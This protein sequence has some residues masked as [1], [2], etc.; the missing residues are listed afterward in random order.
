MVAHA[1]M[2]IN[3]F[4]YLSWKTSR[5]AR[6]ERAFSIVV[7]FAAVPSQSTTLNFLFWSCMGHVTW[8]DIL[9]SV[10][11]LHKALMDISF[12]HNWNAFCT[13]DNFDETRSNIQMML[14]LQAFYYQF[15][16]SVVPVQSSH[17]WLWKGKFPEKWTSVS[18]RKAIQRIDLKT[19]SSGLTKFW[20]LLN[21]RTEIFSQRVFQC[22]HLILFSQIESRL[23]VLTSEI[24]RAMTCWLDYAN[25]LLSDST[26][27]S[28]FSLGDFTLLQYGDKLSATLTAKN[29]T[30]FRVTE[31]PKE[32][33]ATVA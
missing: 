33:C 19:G 22:W 9:F 17:E 6:F 25:Q 26:L 23:L 11:F 8:L 32:F 2:T 1:E 21:K 4:A 3:H 30:G 13:R 29:D 15:A 10:C 20:K 31:C 12:H 27:F 16:L 7:H 5:F 24:S 14:P 28:S 18:L